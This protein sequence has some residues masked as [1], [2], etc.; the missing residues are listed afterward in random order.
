MILLLVQGLRGRWW[1]VGR[2]GRGSEGFPR[3]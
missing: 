1:R 2:R 3:L